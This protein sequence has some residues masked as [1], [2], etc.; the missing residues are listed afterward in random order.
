MSIDRLISI[1]TALV[2]FQSHLPTEAELVTELKREAR[3]LK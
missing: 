2:V 3:A 1:H